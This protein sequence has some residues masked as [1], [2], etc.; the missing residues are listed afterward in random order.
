MSVAI[1]DSFK[2][3]RLMP[4][5]VTIVAD[6]TSDTLTIEGGIGVNLSYNVE[7]DSI[8]IYNSGQGLTAIDD[9]LEIGNTTNRSLK[10]GTLTI[11]GGSGATLDW[12][13]GVG[14]AVPAN[15]TIS[16]A[17]GGYVVGDILTV[18]GGDANA[19][20]SVTT[21]TSGGSV[22]SVTQLSA[23]T[24]YPP[25]SENN[26]TTTP[27]RAQL[28]ADTNNNLIIR[29]TGSGTVFIDSNKALRIPVGDTSVRPAGVT[30]EIRFNSTTTQFEGYNGI[31][32]TSLGGIRDVD[33]NTYIVP[34]TVPDAN[35]NQL[36]FIADNITV[37][38]MDTQYAKFFA[39][40]FVL[41]SGATV[42]RP[43]GVT[44]S[45]RFNTE[46]L[47]FE[48]FDGTS[49][50]SIG[51]VRDVDG[52]TYI[53]P[54]T[55]PGANENTLYFY[56][57]NFLAATLSTTALT[58]NN[59][60]VVANNQSV[61]FYEAANNGTNS[62]EV[63][64]P[65][66]LL[67]SYTLKLP[68]TIGND[69]NLLALGPDGQL[70]F[71]LSDS[72]AGGRITVSAY[73]G[74]D[75]NDGVSKPVKTIKRALEIASGL[76]YSPTFVYNEEACKRD[77]GLIV[78][79]VGYDLAYG[80]N[81]QSILAGYQYY[82]VASSV[83]IGD[84]KP[85]TLRALSYLK[86]LAVATQSGG[87]I[88]T[89]TN[90]VNV[91][92]D[93]VD[94]GLSA[95]P[96]VSMPNPADVNV[97]NAKAK[98]LILANILNG[99][100]EAEIIGW[101][102]AQ[103]NGNIAPFTN[104][105]TYDQAKCSR[106]IR[107]IAYSI[108]YDLTYGGNSQSRFSGLK[109]YDALLN[110]ETLQ[111]PADQKSQTL[112]TL[113]R[114]KYVMTQVAAATTISGGEKY[115]AIAQDISTPGADVNAQNNVNSLIE[116]VRT[117]LNL[118][119]SSAP[120][121]VLPTTTKAQAAAQT[122]LVNKKADI[123]YN[124]I[125]YTSDYKPNGIKVSVDVAAGDYIEQNPI[126]VPD[127][128]S[129]VGA[130]LRACNIRPANANLDFLRVRNASYFTEFT[131]RDHLD[132][133]GR[134]DWTWD[135]AVAFDDPTDELTDRLGYAIMPNTKPTIDVSPYIQNCS[136]IS[137]LGGN[138]AL[139]DGRLVNTPN[140]PQFQIQ[141]ETPVDGPAPEQGKSM[142]ANA[143]TMLTF[144]GTAW[145]VIN[146][147]YI[148]IVSC[149]Q[150]FAL[151]GTYCQSGGYASITNS[152]T[153]FGIYA[154]RASGYSP[155]AFQFDK[156]YIAAT[157][158]A[159]S[160][161]TLTALGFGRVPTQDYVIRFR[162]PAYRQAYDLL[163]AN[164]Q[165]IIDQTSTWIL[166]QVVG[167]IAPFVGYDYTGTNRTKGERD[168]GLVIDA[169]A[170][171]VLTGGNSNSVLAGLSYQ[172]TLTDLVDIAIAS[173]TYAK[174]LAQ[175][176]I[177]STGLSAYAGT[178]FNIITAAI[179]DPTSAP[180]SVGFSNDGDITNTY[181]P[182]SVSTSFD[183]AT[184]VNSSNNVITINSHGFNNGDAIIYSNNGNVDISGL[185][186]EQTYYVI[187]NDVNT[188][189]LAYDETL[190]LEVN[191][192]A[193]GTGIHQFVRSLQEFYIDELIESHSSYQE[194]T[195]AAGSYTFISGSVITGVTGA[196][197]NNA[198]V[199]S[200]DP[201]SRK[202]VV[203]LNKVTV[204]SS[205][206]RNAFDSSSTIDA[207]HGSP[208]ANNIVVTD[209]NAR[210]DLYSATFSIQS[211][212][213]GGLLTNLITLPNKQ[214]WLHRPSIVNSSGH[215][216]EYAGSGTDY[217]ALPQNGGQTR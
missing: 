15:V 191:I 36:K 209:T 39:K 142:V 217:N 155:N 53:I 8:V 61:F 73:Y 202:L 45:I 104:S 152:A 207:D 44:G 86:N 71:V 80:S 96:A 172:D 26:T 30:G 118:G 63:K 59:D 12:T 41:P 19:T 24:G 22:T 49:W 90:L 106:D 42:D 160:K 129:V 194:L 162:D 48:G 4:D 208:A 143:F 204:G 38:T 197:T 184:N 92:Y 60:L 200:Y 113:T 94:Q 156:G 193:T 188:F 170:L 151:N 27:T 79:A 146:D 35:E 67:S 138:G 124:V 131:F 136:I 111:I 139:V 186:N 133:D 105:F 25:L 120:T 46:Q 148:Q 161:Q 16:N 210:N 181:K 123:Q 34:E 211:T 9:S 216:W 18:T 130:G 190:R 165:S 206:I 183:A 103:V 56:T 215:T 51:S 185:D 100:I 28:E 66:N 196:N 132:V 192:L 213:T 3:L 134:P 214:I 147:A 180:D 88:T 57:N 178:K 145:R 149:F 31:A 128:V 109:Y 11:N 115:S 121:L 168:I 169:V 95:A 141:A 159:N 81:W 135:Y 62:I 29:T 203:S 112:A 102:T 87:N 127:N 43:T 97:E 17:G 64:A 13:G 119:S 69:G 166:S 21:V 10:I 173:I 93:I 126:I 201:V 23:G 174:G 74:D 89:V 195:L 150:I 32:W 75:A 84:Q 114:L 47:Q 40:G 37:A 14:S 52:N 2:N 163:L 116:V 65:E 82:S 140:L 199:H 137:F 110:L 122:S 212:S 187:Y 107:Y 154:L 83:V 99:F 198:Y 164:K 177:T 58:I 179:A 20:F 157:G 167:N 1:V 189:K 101:I 6:K 125:A 78:D 158:T 117:I 72:F 7:N 108:A 144:G 77:V 50:I 91:V 153:N 85:E 5:D 205:S 70:E 182:A 176:A 55:V 98:T 54:E 76:V 33:G 68:T 175:T 171:D